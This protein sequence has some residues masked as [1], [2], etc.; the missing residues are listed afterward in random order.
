MSPQTASRVI[1]SGWSHRSG[2]REAAGDLRRSR[3]S[4]CESG[5]LDAYA[6]T[7]LD[8]L[9]QAAIGSLPIT[10]DAMCRDRDMNP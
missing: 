3:S 9:S 7:G 5:A 2:D 8:P 4:T 1:C 6:T 10:S